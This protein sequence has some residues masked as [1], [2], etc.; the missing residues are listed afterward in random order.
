M[1]Y[2]I[3]QPEIKVTQDFIDKIIERY[4]QLSPRYWLAIGS[5]SGNR[6]SIIKEIQDMSEIGKHILLID[7]KFKQAYPELLK[8]MEKQKKD[9]IKRTNK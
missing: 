3:I 1:K 9:D 8:E 6:D 5:W 7:Y 2:F 4:E